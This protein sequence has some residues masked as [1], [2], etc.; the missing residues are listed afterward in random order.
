GTYSFV[1]RS[2]WSSR[3]CPAVLSDID[4]MQEEDDVHTSLYYHSPTSPCLVEWSPRIGPV[5]TQC[6]H[7]RASAP[8]HGEHVP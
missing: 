7:Q 4:N 5:Q 6:Y 8:L 3:A 1:A 2:S